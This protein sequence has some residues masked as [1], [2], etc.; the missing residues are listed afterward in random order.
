MQLVLQNMSSRICHSGHGARTAHTVEQHTQI[1]AHLFRNTT[2]QSCFFRI[3][4]CAAIFSVFREEVVFLELGWKQ[5]YHWCAEKHI[6]VVSQLFRFEFHFTDTDGT[7]TLPLICCQKSL[8]K[9]NDHV[10]S[11]CRYTRLYMIFIT[12]IISSFFI[13]KVFE[14]FLNIFEHFTDF[15]L[16]FK[17]IWAIFSIRIRCL[18]SN[19]SCGFAHQSLQVFFKHVVA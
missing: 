17:R 3:I 9:R 1:Q 7:A 4:C 13:F 18:K 11:F 12:I 15:R 19:Y 14:A 6:S 8:Q 2:H 10:W 5:A 16:F